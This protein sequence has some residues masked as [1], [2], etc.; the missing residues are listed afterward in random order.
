[1]SKHPA[2]TKES[3]HSKAWT[4]T[5]RTAAGREIKEHPEWGN[6]VWWSDRFG[7]CSPLVASI[8]GPMGFEKDAA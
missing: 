3:F 7:V 2:L 1:M 8:G 5:G 6:G 4:S